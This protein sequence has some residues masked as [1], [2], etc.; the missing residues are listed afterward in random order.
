VLGTIV[1]VAGIVIALSVVPLRRVMYVLDSQTPSEASA[2]AAA[3][4]TQPEPPAWKATHVATPKA[5]KAVY[6]T[7]WAAGTEKFRDHLFDLVDT[8]EINAVVLDIKDYTG[9]ISFKVEDPFLQSFG[10]VENRIPDIKELIEELHKRDVYVIG[11]ISTFQDS[12][13][14]DRHPEWAVMSKQGGP[15]EDYK[16]I[17]WLDTGAEP[18]W[19]YVLA[20]AKESYN[21]G[22]DELNFDYIR[23]PSDGPMDD[24]TYIW[25][26]SSTRPE[27]MER[28]FRYVRETVDEQIPDAVISVDF[29][30]LTTFAADDLGI[31]QLL[32]HGLTYFD[33]V[34]PMVYPSHYAK[35]FNG[36]AKP[37]LYPYE[38]VKYS[39]DHAVRKATATTT[40]S[41]YLGDEVIAST[42]PQLY[43]KQT[44]DTDKLRPWLQDFDYGAD[45]TPEMVRAQI[46][47]TYDAGLDSWM[48]WNAG[49]IYTKEALLPK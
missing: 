4:S 35:G 26:A 47:A 10:S 41:F 34:A 29:F 36:F 46:T 19:E 13:L 27:K 12:Y 16:G 5:V 23:F 42:S 1:V 3:T 33:Y 48:L 45:Y 37:A 39:M 43:T 22:F 14:V 8:T 32:E 9:R 25:N 21:V 7:S 44:F 20:I 30:G 28:F 31:G 49:S 11:R 38:I 18:V 17:K 6:L 2:I 15:W 40:T 24:I